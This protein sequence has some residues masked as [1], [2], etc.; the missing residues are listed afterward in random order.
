[1]AN[2]SNFLTLYGRLTDKFGD[3]GLISVIIGEICGEELHIRLWLMSCRVL[4]RGMENAMLN[5]LVSRAKNFG[6]KKIVGY[7][8]PTKKNNMV[9][10]LY[11]NFGF[12]KISDTVWN[13]NISDFVEQE[14]FIKIEETI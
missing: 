14:N 1:M 5:T 7:Y 6:C 9:A 3:N 11:K 10:D 8:F 12:Q 4:K 13:L 2:D